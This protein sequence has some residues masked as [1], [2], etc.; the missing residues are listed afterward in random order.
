MA[1]GIWDV[2]SLFNKRPLD[3]G[4]GD[5]K[6]GAKCGVRAPVGLCVLLYMLDFPAAVLVIYR[7]QLMMHCVHINGNCQKPWKLNY[8]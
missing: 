8:E 7:A 3:G 5:R 6:N 2:K 1:W 4:F